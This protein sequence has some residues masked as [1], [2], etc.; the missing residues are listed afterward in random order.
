MEYRWNDND[1]GK[2]EVSDRNMPRYTSSTINPKWSALTANQGLRGE[3]PAANRSWNY[4]LE[5]M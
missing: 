4:K 1:R 3:E 2:P 5:R